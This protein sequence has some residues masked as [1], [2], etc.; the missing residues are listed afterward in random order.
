MGLSGL[1]DTY[2]VP[3]QTPT[4]SPPAMIPPPPVAAPPQRKVPTN[5][6]LAYSST[7]SEPEDS[8]Y[9]ADICK[10]VELPTKEELMQEIQ[11]ISADS[12]A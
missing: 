1:L 6:R 4:S 9:A 7:E 11:R 12:L 8:P 3:R 5:S 10:F 2:P